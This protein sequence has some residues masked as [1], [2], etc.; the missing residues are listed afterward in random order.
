MPLN[1]RFTFF[2]FEPILGA[3]EDFDRKS[4]LLRKFLLIVVSLAFPKT[5]K[6][7]QLC[8]SR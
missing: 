3:I 5:L 4:C 2:S 7:L 1:L 8:P 6:T